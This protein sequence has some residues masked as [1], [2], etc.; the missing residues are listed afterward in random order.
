MIADLSPDAVVGFL[1]YYNRLVQH[2]QNGGHPLRVSYDSDLLLEESHSDNWTI[3]QAPAFIT[4]WTYTHE[5]LDTLA[6]DLPTSPQT[7]LQL[8]NEEDTTNPSS[9]GSSSVRLI[10]ADLPVRN[11]MGVV[12]DR[13]PP[14]GF[15]NHYTQSLI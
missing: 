8:L 5:H 14:L 2:I 13:F 12:Y 3:Q 1:T 7:V 15:E 6:R 9:A 4:E 11:A 10:R